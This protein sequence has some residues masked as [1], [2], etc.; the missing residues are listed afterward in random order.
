[1]EVGV[2]LVVITP[3]TSA[4]ETQ[5]SLFLHVP[6]IQDPVIQLNVKLSDH[7]KFLVPRDQQARKGVTMLAGIIDHDH[8][9]E[10]E[11]LL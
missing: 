11:Q 2:V 4:L 6:S 5:R 7:F 8:Q 10:I 3:M 1:M 9:K